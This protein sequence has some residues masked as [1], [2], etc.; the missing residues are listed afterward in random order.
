MSDIEHEWQFDG[1]VGP[2][3]HYAGL[4]VGNLASA[5]NAGEA[6]NPRLAALQGLQKMRFVRDLGIKQAFLPP[7]L[8]PLITELKQL[9]FEGPLSMV[10][11]QVSRQNPVLL[12]AIYSSSFM[13]TA[14][15][16]TITPSGDSFDGKMHLTPANLVSQYHRSLE[17]KFSQKILENIFHNQSLFNVHNFLE[18]VAELG[19]EGA[20]NHMRVKLND[21][22]KSLHIF[23]YGKSSKETSKF[24]S[25]QTRLA[26]ETIARNHG[27]APEDC[28]FFEQSPAAIDSGVFHN[29]VIAMSA[30]SLIIAH[31]QAFI[32]EHQEMLQ[33]KANRRSNFDYYK[34]NASDLTLEEA[35]A[36]YLFNSQLIVLPDNQY[37]LVAPTECQNHPRAKKLIDRLLLEGVISQ[38]HYLDVR[39]SMR[40]G[41]GPACL[42]LR[43]PM[44]KAQE[45]AIHSGVVFTDSTYDRLVAWVKTHYRDRLCFD[46]LRD[47]AF[48]RELAAA[49]DALE[50]II[51]MPGLYDS[52]RLFE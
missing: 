46:D 35:V 48:V 2:T 32:P 36:T 14:N 17:A 50:G 27:L 51:G 11:D 10:L 25:R 33:V 1:L 26:S 23:V 20:A 9:G 52:A 47:P 49:Y 30:G 44:T 13:W 28:L 3:H 43:V 34:V 4:A 24:P 41:G 6:S 16:A 7:H 8:R 12:S 29:D 5:H 15:C 38:V 37:A 42:R 22:E 39:E 31:E 40:N 45:S 21:S 18:P 19:D